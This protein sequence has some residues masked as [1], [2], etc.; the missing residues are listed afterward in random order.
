MPQGNTVEVAWLGWY[1]VAA[2]GE[3]GGCFAFWVWLRM[4][5]SPAWII[6]GMRGAGL[7]RN[8]ADADSNSERWTCVCRIR[9]RLHSRFYSLALVRGRRCA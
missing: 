2:V 5:K 8:G 1:I 3:I 9:R 6:P 7:V 4:H